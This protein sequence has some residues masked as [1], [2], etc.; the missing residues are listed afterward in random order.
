LNYSFRVV[1]R[2]SDIDPQQWNALA[3]DH[4]FMRHA[5]LNAMEQAGCAVPQTGWATRYLLLSNGTQLAAAMPIYLKAHSRG[6]YVFDQSWAQAY[7]RHGLPY[8]P[9]LLGAVPF[10]PVPGPRLLARHHADR[11]ALAHRAK[12]LARDHGASSLHILFPHAEDIVA[13]RE[14]GYLLRENVQFHWFNRGY[15]SFDDFTAQLNQK[16]RKKIRQNS[17]NVADAGVD[18]RWIE[19]G[20]I[21]ADTLRFF[22]DCYCQTYLE[23]GNPPYLNLAFFQALLNAMPRQ[24]VL[25]VAYQHGAP[26]A[27]ALNIQ[28]ETTLFGRYWGTLKFVSGLHFETCYIQAIAYCVAHGIDVFQGGAQGE[29]KLFRGLEPVRTWSAHWI[30]DQRYARAIADFLEQ[31]TPAVENYIGILRQHSPFRKPQGQPGDG[32]P[33][34]SAGPGP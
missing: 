5:Y 23:H 6:E 16:N 26:I 10:T 8:Y 19:G 18:F 29:H 33:G 1:D 7:A 30:R 9:K 25:V 28:G 31:E 2:I 4:P 21:D 24:V 12:T 34:G 13:L 20:D 27:C 3:Q 11:V 17:R 15:A 32:P 14:A 22:F